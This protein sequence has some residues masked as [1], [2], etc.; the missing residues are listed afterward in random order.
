MYSGEGFL[1]V[2]TLHSPLE[3]RAASQSDVMMCNQHRGGTRG[4]S[5]DRGGLGSGDGPDTHR[6]PYV[7]KSSWSG[8]PGQARKDMFTGFPLPEA[9]HTAD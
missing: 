7:T 5:L 8:R 4:G 1:G 2:F 9:G 6:A 3:M